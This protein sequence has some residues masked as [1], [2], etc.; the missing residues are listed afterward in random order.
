MRIGVL[1]DLHHDP[2]L[3]GQR[4]RW[5]NDYAPGAVLDRLDAALRSFEQAGADAIL[6]LGDFTEMADPDALDELLGA[7]RKRFRGPVGVDPDTRDEPLGAVRK[8]F[9]GPVGVVDGNHDVGM[10]GFGDVLLRHDV[11]HL[12]A[13]SLALDGVTLA[14]VGIEQAGSEFRVRATTVDG[15]T[16]GLLVVA[17]HFPVLSQA[18][19][20]TGAGMPYSGDLVDREELAA[21]V[22]S[23]HRPAVALTGHIHART[24]EA[25]GPLL[26][27]TV[28]AIIEP[29]FDCTI[30]EIAAGD[31]PEV[32]RTARRLGP[33]RPLDPV[34]APATERWR[35]TGSAW[36]LDPCA[37]VASA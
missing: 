32:T 31:R 21:R 13:T 27:L 26:Q 23:L 7:V 15:A 37:A 25:R 1:S 3:A 17:S 30:V 20:L 34:F 19:V 11:S 35:W 4:G 14:G 2:G 33:K 10:P 18:G 24:S 6:L 28:G 8:R 5:I 29:P 36:G 16:D 22:A 9:R 12:A